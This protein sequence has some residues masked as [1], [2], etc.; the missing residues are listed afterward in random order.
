LGENSPGNPGLPAESAPKCAGHGAA[1]PDLAAVIQ[2][3]P[4]LSD[5]Q[6][7]KILGMIENIYCSSD[8]NR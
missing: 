5:G 1:D 8:V 2:A 4:G 6:R 3:W 7:E